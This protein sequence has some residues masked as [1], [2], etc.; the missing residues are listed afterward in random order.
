MIQYFLLQKDYTQTMLQ[1]WTRSVP[2][3]L[4]ENNFVFITNFDEMQLLL[5]LLTALSSTNIS[6]LWDQDEVLAEGRLF[7]VNV[8]FWNGGAGFNLVM[9]WPN[10]AH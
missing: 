2:L 10:V 3:K 8:K 7:K 5:W 4:L 1:S 6:G 9:G